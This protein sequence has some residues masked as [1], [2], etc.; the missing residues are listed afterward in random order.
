MFSCYEFNIIPRIDWPSIDSSSI[1]GYPNKTSQLLC[2]ITFDYDMVICNEVLF[3]NS[4]NKLSIQNIY[5]CNTKSLC[6]SS[7]NMLPAMG[8]K[9][10]T[11]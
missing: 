5:V 11:M 7:H 3:N 2:N 1:D 8:T 10:M 6:N 9:G 4:D